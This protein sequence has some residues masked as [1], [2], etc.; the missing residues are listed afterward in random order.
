MRRQWRG[1]GDRYDGYGAVAGVLVALVCGVLLVG[2]LGQGAA[3]WLV[4]VAVGCGAMN[5]TSFI[6]RRVTGGK[7]R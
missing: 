7:A 2:V 3:G 4:A 1:W 6:L 5:V